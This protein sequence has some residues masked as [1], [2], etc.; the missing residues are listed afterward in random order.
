ML[1]SK[2]LTMSAGP[3]LP[4]WNLVDTPDSES[5]ARKGMLVQLR[6]GAL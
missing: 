2:P 6:L 4:W 1:N 5:G 3:L